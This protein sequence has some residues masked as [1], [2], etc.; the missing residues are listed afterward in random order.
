MKKDVDIKAELRGLI[1][2]KYRT[3][4]LAAKAWGVSES[5]VSMVLAGSKSPS[6]SM[7]DDAGFRAEQGPVRYVRI[8]RKEFGNAGK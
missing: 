1:L 6:K 3:Q 8:S 5:L 7:L 2:K 4:K